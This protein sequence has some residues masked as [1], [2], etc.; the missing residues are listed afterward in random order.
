M[1]LRLRDDIRIAKNLDVLAGVRYINF[2]AAYVSD[3][4]LADRNTGIALTIGALARVGR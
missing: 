1:E 3:A 4:G 2:A